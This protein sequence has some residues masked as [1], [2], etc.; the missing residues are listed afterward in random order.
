MKNLFLMTAGLW[1]C[2]AFAAYLNIS[3]VS[4]LINS[5]F[6]MLGFIGLSVLS[7]RGIGQ[8][9]KKKSM[10]KWLGLAISTIS[11]ILITLSGLVITIWVAF[12]TFTLFDSS[13]S[14]YKLNDSLRCQAQIFGGATVAFNRVDLL[15]FQNFLFGLEHKIAHQT[16]IDPG[17]EKISLEEE[18]E[19]FANTIIKNK[20]D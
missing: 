18:C 19:K 5:V 17:Y 2:V 6:L 14:S 4:D 3:F 13:P 20:T 7:I 15:L 9:L 16:W 10:P 12:G 1:I 8:F 11:T